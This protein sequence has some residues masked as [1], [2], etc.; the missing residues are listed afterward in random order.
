MN[1][2]VKELGVAA[3][4]LSGCGG[5][6]NGSHNEF[7]NSSLVEVKYLPLPPPALD[8]ALM[9]KV[10]APIVCPQYHHPEKG[11]TAYREEEACI[12]DGMSVES[13]RSKCQTGVLDT[14]YKVKSNEEDHLY[15]R[16]TPPVDPICGSGHLVTA[17]DEVTGKEATACLGDYET[18]DDFEYQCAKKKAL[19]RV[20]ICPSENPPQGFWTCGKL[21][22]TVCF[23]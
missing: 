4:L 23:D 21:I 12:E 3:V 6:N 11:R 16:C 7:Y 20:E 14:I 13:L 2:G 10:E 18:V 8:P 17:M 19:M 9:P 1:F 15:W 5:V 22:A